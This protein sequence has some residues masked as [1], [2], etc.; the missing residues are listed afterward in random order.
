LQ[1]ELANVQFTVTMGAGE[2]VKEA[3]FTA[4]R[5]MPLLELAIDNKELSVT[6][7]SD[8]AAQGEISALVFEPVIPDHD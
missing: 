3:V 4:V 5:G 8:G 2:K 6:I 7:L 1:L